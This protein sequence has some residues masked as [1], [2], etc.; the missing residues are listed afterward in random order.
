MSSLTNPVTGAPLPSTA[1]QRV[2]FL[3]PKVHVYAVPPLTSTKGYQA[4]Q[5]TANQTQPIFNARLRLVE[6]AIPTNPSASDSPEK[7]T[8]DLLLEDPSTAQLFAACPYD[9]VSAVEQTT[10]SSRFFALTVV[11]PGS[12]RKATLGIG[13]EERSDA[14]DFNIALQ[15]ARRVLGLDQSKPGQRPGRSTAAAPQKQEVKRDFSLKE[16]EMI[17]VNI[18]GRAGASP[19][20]KAKREDEGA[21]AAALFSIKPPPSPGSGGGGGDGT[22]PFVPPPPSAGDARTERREQRA[23]TQQPSAQDL[24]F[25]D[26]EFGEFQ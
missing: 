2:L 21:N 1:I 5:W 19:G 7:V 25:D 9:K 10:D 15:D 16:G 14:F 24:G 23:A 18:G 20:G 26:G 17:T 12:K 22:M 11:D 13:F 3:H 6:T 4:S 8:N